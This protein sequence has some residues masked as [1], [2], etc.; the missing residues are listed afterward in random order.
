MIE[1]INELSKQ[2]QQFEYQSFLLKESNDLFK[3]QIK[4]QNDALISDKNYKE[5]SIELE[6]K[7]RK[8]KI[9]PF[10][11]Y[12]GG[13]RG[14]GATFMAPLTNYGERAYII[15]IEEISTENINIEQKCK[16]KCTIE[17]NQIF[18][19][20]GNSKNNYIEYNVPFEINIIFK[21]EDGNKYKQNIKRQ[22][23]K[24]NVGMPEEI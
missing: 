6:K 4:I 22:D 19:L 14:A 21:D 20:Q 15:G 11:R 13:R 5:K 9:K 17:K 12:M 10:F 3:N 18:Q 7:K 24:M 23:L 16:Q 2:T 8:S 1:Q